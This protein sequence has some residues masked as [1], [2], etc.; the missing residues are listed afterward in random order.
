MR[1]EAIEFN[2]YS[3]GETDFGNLVTTTAQ[4]SL[5]RLGEV[6]TA[7]ADQIANPIPNM[8]FSIIVIGHSDRQDRS[9][10]NCDQ[11]RESEATAARDRALSAWEWIK[12][13]VN[14]LTDI[15]GVDA[16]E[17]WDESMHVTWGLVFAGAGMLTFPNPADA[18]RP[19]NRRVVVLVTQFAPEAP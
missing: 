13:K 1:L 14:V 6:L 16:G 9:D 19:L 4:P 2:G 8:C 3:S 10:L 5:A 18:E 7:V 11:R 15:A 12:E 17:W